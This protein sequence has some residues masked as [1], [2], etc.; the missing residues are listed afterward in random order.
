MNIN[1]TIPTKAAVAFKLLIFD[2]EM[3]KLIHGLS[4]SI[5]PDSFIILL[6]S[7]DI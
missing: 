7:C 3:S 4:S 5:E 1:G 6:E 2:K